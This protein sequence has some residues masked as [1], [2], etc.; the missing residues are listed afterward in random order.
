MTVTYRCEDHVAHVRLDRPEARNAFNRQLFAELDEAMFRFRDDDEARVCV[1]DAAGPAFSV[2]FDIKDG[3]RAMGD[4]GDDGRGFRSTYLDDDM[5]GKPVIVAIHGHCVGQGVANALFGDIRI[6]S[7]DARFTLS[8][9]RI[10]ISA[11]A[12]PQLMSDA[13]GGSQARYLLVSGERC[14][15]DWALRSGLVHEVVERETLS[16]RAFALARSILQQ[17]PL[18]TRAHKLILRAALTEPRADVAKLARR[19]RAE[20]ATSDDFREGRRAFLE[21]R[22]PDWTAR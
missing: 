19:Y 16:A 8:E 9:A 15:A 17:A 18:A 1:M 7:P 13:I 3:D 14:D 12:L 10:G 11:Q 5:G 22:A 2:V 6:C 21:R 4:E 20:T